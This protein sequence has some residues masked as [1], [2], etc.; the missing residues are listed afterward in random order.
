LRNLFSGFAQ[1]VQRLLCNGLGEH[2]TGSA[3][4]LDVS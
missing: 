3:V 1:F 2:Q 4:R